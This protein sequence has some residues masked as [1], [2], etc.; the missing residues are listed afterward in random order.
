MSL[1]LAATVLVGALGGLNLVLLLGV[2]RRL[3]EHT[4][5]LSHFQIGKPLLEVGDRIA[6][7]ATSTAH[8]QRLTSESLASGTLV[9]FLSPTCGPCQEKAPELA[10]YARALPD[11]PDQVLAVVVGA[12]DE[13]TE[14]VTR[15]SPVVT[16][17][18]EGNGGPLSKAF[19]VQGF[20]TVLRVTRGDDGR[21]VVAD[22][23]VDLS[24]LP[25]SA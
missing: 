23:N 2:I 21:L 8:G 6:D 19:A 15:L 5:V 4:E 17:A 24:P 3:R 7:F 16:V 14:M 18:T 25:A 12:D 22:N 10:A 13:A 20:P 1:L 9:A 11:G